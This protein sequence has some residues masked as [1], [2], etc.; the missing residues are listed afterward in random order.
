MSDGILQTVAV[1]LMHRG[2]Y[3]D[4]V[5]AYKLAV[6]LHPQASWAY[7]GMGEAY[8]MSADRALAVQNFRKA[9]A[10]DSTNTVAYE[11]LQH[12]R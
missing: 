3:A 8:L 7:A 6:A 4:A 2:R 5:E 1:K 9:L 11:Y 10:T 12:V